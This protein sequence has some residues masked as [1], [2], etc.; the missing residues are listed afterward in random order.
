MTIY[1]LEHLW[2]P[3]GFMSPA[4]VEV[5]ASGFVTTLGD[6]PPG[7]QCERVRGVVVPGVPNLHSHAFQRAMAGLA[8]HRVGD[9]DFWSWRDAMYAFVGELTPDDVE[10]LSLIHISEPTRPY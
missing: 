8:E 9:D 6:R 2:R 4:W 7:V 3:Q 1:E 10:T 5:D